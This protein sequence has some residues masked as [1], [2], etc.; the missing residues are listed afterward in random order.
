MQPTLPVLDQQEFR[1]YA[2]HTRGPG[3]Q[4]GVGGQVFECAIVARGQLLAAEARVDV[5][6]RWIAAQM[7]V[8]E[9]HRAGHAQGP[10]RV[11]R[12]GQYQRQ[13]QGVVV[14]QA[15]HVEQEFAAFA[16][17]YQ[18]VQECR[19]RP[20]ADFGGRR[21]AN[22]QGQRNRPGGVGKDVIGQVVH[23]RPIIG[24]WLQAGGREPAAIAM[25]FDHGVHGCVHLDYFNEDIS[26][27][28]SLCSLYNS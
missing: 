18:V 7:V 14:T 27:Y 28:L 21:E 22:R 6:R 26:H 15:E 4:H 5:W 23:P 10:H 25:D 9:V 2:L 3:R 20:A 8:V 24:Q 1:R 13:H 16:L 17:R 11:E 12:A 19:R